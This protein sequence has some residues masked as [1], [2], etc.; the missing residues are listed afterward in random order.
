MA[1][2]EGKRVKI[3]GAGGSRLHLGEV[4]IVGE[5]QRYFGKL[6]GC[7][8]VQVTYARALLRSDP[9]AA[10]K[11]KAGGPGSALQPFY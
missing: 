1:K 9:E 11:V 10:A 7:G 3:A 6:F 8:H 5:A 2:A 4:E